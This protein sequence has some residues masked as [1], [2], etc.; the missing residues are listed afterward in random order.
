M[1]QGQAPAPQEVTPQ[2]VDDAIG[3]F[4]GSFLD[5]MDQEDGVQPE[6]PQEV[7]AAEQEQ[8]EAEEPEAEAQPETEA[9]L[10]EIDG[11][12][13]QL[14][15]DLA[16][17]VKEWR[18]A[19][20]RQEDYTRKT[21]ELAESRKANERIL[22]EAAR[23]QETAKQLAPAYAQVQAMASR[24][25][26]IRQA[27]TAELRANDPIEFNNLQGE[28]AI[29][30]NDLNIASGQIQQLEGGL[31]Q[32]REQLLIQSMQEQLPALL[33]EIPEIAKEEVRA[34]LTQYAIDSGLSDAA[35]KQIKFMPAA[36]K[37]LWKAQ[38][39]EALTKQQAQAQKSLKS[40]TATLPPVKSGKSVAP[41]ARQ[42]LLK[43]WKASG[44]KHTDARL[45]ALLPKF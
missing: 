11:N 18:G 5:Q 7:E 8:P 21:Q 32:Q 24:A 14:P 19:G 20:L 44:G 22:Q 23:L 10:L 40:K 33:N 43:E 15:K 36:V 3:A 35:I 26:A 6:Q 1:E 38:Q 45:D 30:V 27:L 9:E 13:Y 16:E 4:A 31:E 34:S 39:Y 29:L 25:Q 28:Y 12:Q 17:K 41:D 42:K 37:I 2:N